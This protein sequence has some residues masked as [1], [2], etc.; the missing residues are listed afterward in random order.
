MSESFESC[1]DDLNCGWQKI[2][3]LEYLKALQTLM[4]A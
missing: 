3:D 1:I 4:Q 2:I